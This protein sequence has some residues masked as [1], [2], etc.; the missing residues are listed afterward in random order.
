MRRFRYGVQVNS[1]GL[2]EAQPERT[3]RGFVRKGLTDVPVVVG[4]IIPP[5][6]AVA[7]QQAGVAAIFA[8]KDF[9]LTEIM[10]QL[11]TA[12]CQANGLIPLAPVA[13]EPTSRVAEHDSR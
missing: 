11:V 9:R 10:A 6:D 5:A 1:L 7:L 12:I 4:G 8:P 13:G 2:T 3:C